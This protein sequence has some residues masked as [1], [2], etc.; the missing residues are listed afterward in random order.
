[1]HIPNYGD[2]CIGRAMHLQQ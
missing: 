1:M 2:L